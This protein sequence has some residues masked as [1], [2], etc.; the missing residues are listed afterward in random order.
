MR[1]FFVLALCLGFWGAAPAAADEM[2]LALSRLRLPSEDGTHFV[3]DQEGWRWLVGQLGS[4]ITPSLTT[5]GSSLGMRGFEVRLETSITPLSNPD[6]CDPATGDRCYWRR[7]TTGDDA[8]LPGSGNRFQSN[9]HILT[10]LLLRKGLPYGVELAASAGRLARTDTWVW[11]GEVKLS[12]LEGFRESWPALFP[13]VAV[14][15]SVA[16]M[17][18][19]SELSLTV[20]SLDLLVSK[21]LVAGNTLTL[22]PL[23]GV[24]LSWIFADSEVVDLTPEN[25]AWSNCQAIPGTPFIEDPANPGQNLATRTPACTGNASDYNN[26]AQFERIRAFRPRMALGLQVRYRPLVVTGT[27]HWDLKTPESADSAAGAIGAPRQWNVAVS[28]G[29][30]Y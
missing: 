24:Q 2:D 30:R 10:R 7:G 17:T 6:D 5:P 22:T 19:E 1:R 20:A 4:S 9:N 18:G 29:L 12:L 15:G 13:D 28:A 16:T 25:D 26:L 3:P 14:R 27:I 23:V 21:D 8:S 11:G